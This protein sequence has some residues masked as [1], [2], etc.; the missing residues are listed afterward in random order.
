MNVLVAIWVKQHILFCTILSASG[1]LAD[2][3][4]HP[5]RPIGDLVVTDRAETI[6]LPPE[7]K[8]F[9]SS[10][11]GICHL[12]SKAF[13]EVHAPCGVIRIGFC[14]DFGVSLDWHKCCTK[15]PAALYAALLVR[16]VSSEDP[17]PIVHALEVFLPHPVIPVGYC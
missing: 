14:S 9:P 5:S 12:D 17:V 6:L 4:D 7:E 2:T 3:M 8:K 15:E 16:D 13:L 11:E 10:Q 1:F